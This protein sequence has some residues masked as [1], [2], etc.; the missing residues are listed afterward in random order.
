MVA[1]AAPAWI[2]AIAAVVP[3][4]TAVVAATVVAATDVVA[5]VV[6]AVI[7]TATVCWSS[8]LPACVTPI[9]TRVAPLA[10]VEDRAVLVVP[11][12]GL[13]LGYRDYR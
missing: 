12:E 4:V 9:A 5:A 13:V 6:A 7:T 11:V 10:A 3:I 1:I 2:V 8:I